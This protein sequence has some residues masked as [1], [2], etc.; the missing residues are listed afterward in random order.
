MRESKNLSRGILLLFIQR[1]IQGIALPFSKKHLN[2]MTILFG[3]KLLREY[4]NACY[5][6]VF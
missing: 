1:R 2:I 3:V 4:S 5:E 6:R